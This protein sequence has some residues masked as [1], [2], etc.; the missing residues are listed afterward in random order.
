MGRYGI[1]S[2]EIAAKAWA[3]Q[4]YGQTQ[5]FDINTSHLKLV[6]FKSLKEFDIWIT[7]ETA[8]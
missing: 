5:L 4:M 8:R 6:P 3:L 1:A 2:T 7:R